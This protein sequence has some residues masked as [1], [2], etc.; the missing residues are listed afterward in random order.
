M[1]DHHTE[2]INMFRALWYKIDADDNLK[3]EDNL[4]QLVAIG[5]N[6][7]NT[8][9]KKWITNIFKSIIRRKADK[10]T[11]FMI[12]MYLSLHSLIVVWIRTFLVNNE[13]FFWNTRRNIANNLL[14]LLFHS[15]L[16][17]NTSVCYIVKLCKFNRLDRQL[18]IIDKFKLR[19]ISFLSWNIRVEWKMENQNFN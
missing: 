18:R 16:Q 3:T 11:W 12:W 15:H 10:C 7:H 8:H 17:Y 4:R 2:F 9:S 1:S 19:N 6:T 13:I 14:D 5:T